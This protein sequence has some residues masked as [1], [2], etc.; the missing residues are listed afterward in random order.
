MATA[1]ISDTSTHHMQTKR[2][3]I[4]QNKVSTMLSKDRTVRDTY[5]SYYRLKT[6]FR[7]VLMDVSLRN[8]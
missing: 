8:L 7:D 3:L 6:C 1:H 2:F 5:T 4:K